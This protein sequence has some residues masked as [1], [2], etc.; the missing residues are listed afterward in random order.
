MAR[1]APEVGGRASPR[2][3]LEREGAFSW[4]MLAPGVLFLIAFVAYPFFYGIYL[5]LQE[6]RSPRP[7]SSWG[8]GT[9]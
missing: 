6:R 1:A 2:R 5:S 7:A 4:I 8:W 3:L 9:S